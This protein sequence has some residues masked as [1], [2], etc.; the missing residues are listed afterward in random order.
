MT[1]L[2][3]EFKWLD[4]SSTQTTPW[5]YL[6]TPCWRIFLPRHYSGKQSNEMGSAF[7][8][9]C[10]QQWHPLSPANENRK[11]MVNTAVH[12]GNI[13]WMKT[14]GWF[15]FLSVPIL[16][17]IEKNVILLGIYVNASSHYSVLV[18]KSPRS[19]SGED[20]DDYSKVNSC[21]LHLAFARKWEYER[22]YKIH[23]LNF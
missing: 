14:K 7:C 12:P 19:A 4:L 16:K 13:S 2:I 1:P 11:E 9:Q 21:S 15:S 6:E 3:K 23:N 20:E 10:S 18:R 22:K 17:F 5:V 8:I